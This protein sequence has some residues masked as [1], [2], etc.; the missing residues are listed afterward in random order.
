MA[1]QELIRTCKEIALPINRNR[2]YFTNDIELNQIYLNL[3]EVMEI[4]ML[5]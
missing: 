5:Y 4:C 2:F 3:L 1:V